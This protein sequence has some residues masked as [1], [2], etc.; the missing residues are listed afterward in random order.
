MDM[1]SQ[2]YLGQFQHLKLWPLLLKQFQS[3]AREKFWELKET[4]LV[5]GMNDNGFYLPLIIWRKS[6]LI[7]YCSSNQESDRVSEY[8]ETGQSKTHVVS[9]EKTNVKIRPNKLNLPFKF[10]VI[11]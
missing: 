10:V 6:L 5:M 7:Q 2:A 3:V 4:G 8:C 9:T 11:V 1:K